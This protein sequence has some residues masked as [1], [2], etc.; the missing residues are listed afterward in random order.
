MSRA[1]ESLLSRSCRNVHTHTQTH[2]NKH[3]YTNTVYGA[4]TATYALNPSWGI[5]K[6]Q[7]AGRGAQVGLIEMN[8]TWEGNT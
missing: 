2:A 7:G 4:V 8:F 6:S 3:M 1:Q 5:D